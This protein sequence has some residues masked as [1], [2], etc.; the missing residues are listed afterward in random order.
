MDTLNILV[1]TGG[2][3]LQSM[4]TPQTT[5]LS[6]PARRILTPGTLRAGGLGSWTSGE[7]D[8]EVAGRDARGAEGRGRPDRQGPR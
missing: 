7:P 6:T 5:T 4:G 8:D 1:P 2:S 3:M